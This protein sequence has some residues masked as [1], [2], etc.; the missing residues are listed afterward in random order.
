MIPFH[1]LSGVLLGSSQLGLS[2]PRPVEDPP[3]GI[4]LTYLLL[5]QEL[6]RMWLERCASGGD[7]GYNLIN[8]AARE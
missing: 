3:R 4:S 8:Q 2:E 5:R 6:C 7:N 1:L